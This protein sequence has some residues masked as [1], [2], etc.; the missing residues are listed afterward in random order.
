MS[1]SEREQQAQGS[2]E[3]DLAGSGPKLAMFA[4]LAAGEAMPLRE[5]DWRSVYP[6]PVAPAVAGAGAIRRIGH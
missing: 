5:R 6:P 3:D 4:R 2:V 1:I